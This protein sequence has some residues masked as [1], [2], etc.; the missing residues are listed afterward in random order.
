MLFR[1][2]IVLWSAVGLVAS[3]A[4]AQEDVVWEMEE[5]YWRYVKAGEV[6]KYISLWHEDF[7]GWPCSTLQPSRKANIGGWVREIR[8]KGI[9]VTYELR[10]EAVQYFGEVAVVHYATPLVYEYPDG[11]ITGEGELLKFTH[12]WMKV[13]GQW[14][15]IGGMCAVLKPT[16][17]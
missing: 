7:V 15:I 5:A 4:V 17:R 9:K 10:R 2:A 13:K 8:D 1:S 11:R 14:Q 12:T 6:D 3:V 16:V